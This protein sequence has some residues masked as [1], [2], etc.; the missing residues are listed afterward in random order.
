MWLTLWDADNG[1]VEVGGETRWN[2]GRLEEEEKSRSLDCARSRRTIRDSKNEDD[3]R[4]R[5]KMPGFPTQIVGTPTNRG[6]ARR[7]KS[8][9]RV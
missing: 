6:K 3:K 5:T 1:S 9:E 4:R 7:Y 8:E 2:V